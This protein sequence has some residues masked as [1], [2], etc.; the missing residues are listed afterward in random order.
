VEA[1]HALASHDVSDPLASSLAAFV[2]PAAQA[3][4]ALED[5]NSFAAHALAS[6][7]VS[8]PLASS[9]AAFVVPAAQAVHALE[10]TYSFAP[11]S[12]A[13]HD[14]SDPPASSLAAFVVPAA[15][16]VHALEDTNS[17]AAHEFAEH[18]AA[19]SVPAL[20]EDVPDTV[21]PELH[22][23]WHVDPLPREFV[24]SPAPPFVGGAEASHGFTEHVAAVTST[25]MS[26]TSVI[27]Y[28]LRLPTDI[29]TVSGMYSVTSISAPKKSASFM[30]SFRQRR[31]EFPSLS[32]QVR[33]SI[34]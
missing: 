19:V 27:V 14:V 24:Q 28:V 29:M 15:Q 8:D 21:Y 3:V 20:H 9:L 2:V 12:V 22:V 7:D 5:T 30:N 26:S 25:R 32:G 4:H 11:H 13:S 6:H 34:L 33:S 16:A 31:A 1:V 18:V 17:F 23:G 10:D